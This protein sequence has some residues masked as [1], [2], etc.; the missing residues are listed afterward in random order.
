MNDYIR[1]VL[2]HEV[3]ISQQEIIII[4]PYELI[5]VDILDAAIDFHCFPSMLKRVQERIP[6][7]TEEVI[8]KAIWNFDSNVNCRIKKSHDAKEEEQWKTWIQPACAG[9]RTYIR[10]MI[11]S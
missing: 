2:Q 5:K 1:R 3:Y 6:F 10:Y 11:D 8:R 7:L 4:E 9:Y